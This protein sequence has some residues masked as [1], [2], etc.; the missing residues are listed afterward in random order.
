MGYSYYSYHHENLWDETTDLNYRWFADS[1]QRIFLAAFAFDCLTFLAL[2]TFLVWACTIRPS[3]QPLKGVIAALVMWIC[4]ELLSLIYEILELAAAEVKQYYVI[5]FML[6]ELFFVIFSCVLFLVFYQTIHMLLDRLTDSGK[7]YAPLRII[8]WA[9]LGLVAVLSLAE[10]A[11]NVALYYKDVEQTLTYTFIENKRKLYSALCIIYFIMAF[12]IL[13]WTIFVTVKAGTHR[14]ASRMPL[15]SLIAAS[16]CWFGYTLM[17]GIVAIRYYLAIT[18]V[19]NTA[20]YLAIVESVFGFVFVVGIFTGLLLCLMN[21][22]KLGGDHDKA[23]NSV[24]HPYDSNQVFQTW[25]PYQQQQPP[26]PQLVQHH[27]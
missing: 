18:V 10:F 22:F 23:P 8:H 1:Y 24:Q 4:F 17:W 26:Q 16:V 11:V 7:P 2:I 3:N 14:F 27:R 13:V 5:I 21:W 9:I 25:Q 20:D 15:F 19:T 12:E 6:V